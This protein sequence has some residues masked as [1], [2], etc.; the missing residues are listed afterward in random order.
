MF[1]VEIQKSI[2]LLLT[3]YTVRCSRDASE[4]AAITMWCEKPTENG[5]SCLSM[6]WQLFLNTEVDKQECMP[7]SEPL[8]QNGMKSRPEMVQLKLMLKIRNI[9]MW[10]Q[11]F[12]NTLVDKQVC[13]P[14]SEPLLPT[15]MHSRPML[16]WLKLALEIWNN[17]GKRWNVAA[18][19][20]KYRDRWATVHASRMLYRHN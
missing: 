9:F 18:V 4:P 3:S 1:A 20:Y 12:I 15:G 11:L 5:T 2:S 13:V 7:A 14:A 8:L 17:F 6:H 10:Q 16:V 19:N